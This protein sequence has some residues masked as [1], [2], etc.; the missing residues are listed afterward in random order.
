M[1]SFEPLPCVCIY[2]TL[3]SSFQCTHTYTHT[4]D[5]VDAQDQ[6]MMSCKVSLT[7]QCNK[8]SGSQIQ[9]ACVCLFEHWDALAASCMHARD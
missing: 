1:L 6:Y 5:V 2:E 7:H 9:C 4:K 3:M 8:V